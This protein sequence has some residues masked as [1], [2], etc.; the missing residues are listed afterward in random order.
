MAHPCP[1]LI[2]NTSKPT[3]PPQKQPVYSQLHKTVDKYQLTNTNK[4]TNART[5]TL[6]RRIT[7]ATEQDIK[8][9]MFTIFREI[10]EYS[11]LE[12]TL[13]TFLEMK[14]I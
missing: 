13:A 1:V 10:R 12:A 2:E 3:L 6:E 7:I 9:S 14:K 8:M 5:F 4:I 11:T